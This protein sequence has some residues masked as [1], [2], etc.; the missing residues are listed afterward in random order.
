MKT[1]KLTYLDGAVI[2]YRFDQLEVTGHT[3]R[4]KQSHERLYTI[5]DRD[6][7]DNA[8]VIF[9]IEDWMQHPNRSL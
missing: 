9:G 5:A 1:L 8:E 3:L 7:L 6:D 4:F 2:N